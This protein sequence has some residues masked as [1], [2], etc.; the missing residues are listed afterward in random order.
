MWA[1]KEKEK[2]LQHTNQLS[3]DAT[4]QSTLFKQV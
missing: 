1:E 3:S 2:E 4:K